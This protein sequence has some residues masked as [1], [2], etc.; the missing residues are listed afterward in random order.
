MKNP[1]IKFWA[2]HNDK[3]LLTTKKLS[4]STQMEY[5]GFG[6]LYNWIANDL[7]IYLPFIEIYI[8]FGKLNYR[9]E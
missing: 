1:F 3:D 9:D 6:F 7:T 5:I 4:I 2:K 8:V